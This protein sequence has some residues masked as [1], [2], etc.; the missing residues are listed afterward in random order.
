MAKAY[1]PGLKV[2][3]R[4]T[5]RVRRLLPVTGE[6]RVKVGESV[7]AETVVAQTFLEGDVFPIKVAGML[8]VNPAELIPLM[9]KRVGDSV[10]VGDA[11]ARSKGIFGM[12]KTEAKSTAKGTL[13]SVSES[14]GMVIIRG[15]QTPVQVCAYV[16]GKIIEVIPNEGVV[17]E[18]DAL[19]VQGIFGVGGET[20]GPL[21]IAG[22]SHAEDLREEHIDA[23]MKGAV[24]VGGARMTAGGIRRAREVGVSALI[25]GGIDDAD[26]RDVLGYDLGVAVTGSEKIGITLLVTE[27]FGDIAMAKRTFQLLLAHAGKMASVNGATQ[28][29]AGVMRPEIAVPLGEASS[30]EIFT[31]GATAGILDIGTPVRIIRDP[32]FGLLGSVNALPEQPAVL[33]SGSKARVLEVALESGQRVT[34]PRA[35]VE[36]VGD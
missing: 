17:V 20:W 6:V 33:G 34:V 9:L 32:H 16:A 26:L 35:N 27:G 8:S 13:E 21:M 7:S 31:G 24:V 22:K 2:T 10:Q 5:Y 29:R 1:T 25:C 19:F 36:L 28:I 11:L 14:T 18:T 4:T 23:S 30:G 15:A 3:A 12:M